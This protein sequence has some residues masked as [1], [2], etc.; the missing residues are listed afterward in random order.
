MRV[1]ALVCLLVTQTGCAWLVGADFDVHPRSPDSG[2]GTC[3]APFDCVAES[4]AQFCARLGKSCESVTDTDN[5]C[6]PR[7]ADCGTCADGIGCVDQVCKAPVCTTFDYLHA[8]Y[9]PWSR[10]MVQDMMVAGSTSGSIMYAPSQADCGFF[11]VF[12]ADETAPGTGTYTSREVTELLTIAGLV[13]AEGTLSG[14][15]L[16]F[17][18]PT[19]DRR[20]LVAVKRSGL[21]L[22]DF[23]PPSDA[24]FTAING[25]LARTTGSFHMPALSPDGL[26]I[27]YKVN[28]ISASADGIYRATRRS[29]SVLFDAGARVAAFTPDYDYVTS[30]SSDRLAIFLFK[31]FN[32]WV[33]TRNSTSDEFS[34][35]NAPNPPPEIFGWNHKLVRQDCSTLVGEDSLPGGCQ[36][37]DIY[38]LYRQ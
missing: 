29:T 19:A 2:A 5:C 36:N 37:E 17:V 12:L 1:L 25:W 35:P 14:D 23:G 18:A 6:A 8:L 13:S 21:Q 33:F 20:S 10:S 15:G 34:N 7:T 9:T 26:E 30:I 28:D 31:Q 24:D 22:T 11:L 32:S 3:S 4:D 38:F 16:R 27:Y